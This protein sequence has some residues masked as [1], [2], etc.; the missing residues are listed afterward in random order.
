M[1][2]GFRIR[3]Q[4]ERLDRTYVDEFATLPVSVVSDVMSRLVSGG[5]N[6]RPMHCSGVLA[7][8]ALTVKTRPGDNLMLHKAI[9]MA[10]PGDVIVVDAGGDVTNSLMG[11][12]MLAHAI[13]RGVAGF[14]LNGAIRDAQA[15][16]HRNLPVYALGVTHRGPYRDGPGEIGLP[17]NLGGMT[18][19]PGDLVLGDLD[20]VVSVARADLATVLAGAGKKHASEQ[21]QMQQTEDGSVDKSWI[22]QV[23]EQKGCVYL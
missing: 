2:A 22:D 13:K 7:G 10:Q 17:I 18:V 3:T 15:F 8:A 9:E 19:E 11:E 16:L 4:W 5:S 6:L 21:V 20:G 12:L 23:L 14:V 1:T